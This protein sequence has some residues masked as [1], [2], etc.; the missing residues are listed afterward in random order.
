LKNQAQE[1][2]CYFQNIGFQ[3]FKVPQH[4]YQSDP[5]AVLE[6]V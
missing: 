6:P 2:F 1:L 5:K 3:D 4:F